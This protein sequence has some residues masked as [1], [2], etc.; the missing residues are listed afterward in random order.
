MRKMAN[1]WDVSRVRRGSSIVISR[2]AECVRSVGSVGAV[3]TTPW[4]LPENASEHQE[5]ADFVRWFRRRFPGVII[6]A[7]PNGG[8][9]QKTVAA[10]L[11]I[12]GVVPGVPDLFCPRFRWFC[13]MKTES[14]SA[15]PTQRAMHEQLRADG[16]TVDVCRG[17]K[18]AQAAAESLTRTLP[19]ESRSR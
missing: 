8:H 15:T 16:Y 3:L 14:G 13:E 6:F 19:F 5:Q 7:I 11:K 17:S 1:R 4:A 12:E 9:R 18:E 10:R 2:D